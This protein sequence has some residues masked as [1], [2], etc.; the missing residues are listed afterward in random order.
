ME[1]VEWLQQMGFNKYEAEAYVT[2]ALYGPLT[3]YEVGKRSQVPLSRS[4]EV[5]ERLTEKGWA[6]LQP[7]DPPRYLALPPR[8]MLDRLRFEQAKRLE[9]L[10]T[11]LLTIVERP[12]PPGFWIVK[13]REAIMARIRGLIGDANKQVELA[14]GEDIMTALKSTLTGL[15]GNVS[16]VCVPPLGQDDSACMVCIDGQIVLVGNVASTVTCQALISTEPVLLSVVQAH[17]ALARPMLV[18]K[19]APALAE[20]DWLVW[21]ARKQQRL[22]QLRA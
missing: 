16:I 3:G 13:G 6:I 10:T 19:R 20:S 1:A 15:G 5:L 22:H 2:L 7:G 4:Y 17:F 14:A 8:A 11:T 9:A 12:Q 21:E 18:P